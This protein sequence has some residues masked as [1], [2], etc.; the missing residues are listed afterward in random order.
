MACLRR[1]FRNSAIPH[2]SSLESGSSRPSLGPESASRRDFVKGALALG[3]AALVPACR[4]KDSGAPRIAI[5]GAGIAGLHAAHVLAKGGVSSEVFEA[6]ARAGGRILTLQGLMAD[7][8]WTEAGGEF[9]DSSH[10]DMLSLAKEFGIEVQDALGGDR[11]GLIENAWLFGGKA[12]SEAE[13][14]AAVKDASG[15]MA[16]DMAALPPGISAGAGGLAADLDKLSVSAYLQSRG[17]TGWLRDLIETAYVGEFDLDAGDQSCL[18]LLTMVS[19]DVSEGRF[20]VFGESDER[21][22]LKGGNQTLTD[23]LAAKY[24]DRIRFA[25]RLEAIDAEGGGYRLSFQTGGGSVER[26]ADAVILTLPFTLLR[27]VDIRVDLPP[28]KRK[29][30]AELGYGTNAK[31]FL[32]Y[33]A[34]PWRKAGYSGTF[35]TDGLV[36]NGWDHTRTQAGPAGGITI[37]QGGSAGLELGKRSPSSQAEEFSKVLDAMFPGSQAARN[38]STGAFHWPTYPWSLGSYAS[39]KVGQ[40]TTLAGEESKPV[41][42]L[43]FGGE[44]CS[45]DFQG[46]MNGGAETGRRAAEAVLSKWRKGS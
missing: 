21:Y 28:G 30:I 16:R 6:G 26:R 18:N 39:Y 42:N 25:H 15:A 20:K 29:A 27:N 10:A 8:L 35:Y 32:G 41:G 36:Q 7:G 3:A 12:R 24:A 40:W 5:V 17:V 37:F 13:V 19:W 2:G 38:G 43:F 31:L 9:I 33:S 22:R 45:R 46:Y 4:P 23:A 1:C 14:A 34:R 44:H 11:A